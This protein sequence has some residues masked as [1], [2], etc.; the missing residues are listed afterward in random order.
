MENQRLR[1]KK[2]SVLLFP[3]E[4]FILETKAQ[5]EGITKSSYIRNMIVQGIDEITYKYTPEDAKILGDKLT[6]ICNVLQKVEYRSFVHS[7]FYENDVI[8]MTDQ[9]MRLICIVEDYVYS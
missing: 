6:E 2:F 4:Y 9:L 3:E 1:K 5:D 8:D 7:S